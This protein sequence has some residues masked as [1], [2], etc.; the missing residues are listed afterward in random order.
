[1]ST[2]LNSITIIGLYGVRDYKIIFSDNRMI[3]VGE[4][5]SGK[6]TVL[7]IIYYTLSANWDSLFEFKF[8]EIQI[9][10]MK[11]GKKHKTVINY[12][13][14]TK[15]FAVQGIERLNYY[16]DMQLHTVSHGSRRP[17]NLSFNDIVSL[18]VEFRSSKS[19]SLNARRGLPPD[20]YKPLMESEDVKSFLKIDNQIRD[21]IDFQILYL[22]TYR[23]IEEQLKTIFPF[24]DSSEWEKKRIKIQ[25]DR[26]FEI[27]EFGMGDV[28]AAVEKKQTELQRLS[29]EQQNKLTLGYLGEIVTNKYDKVDIAKI[30]ALSDE[31]IS[32][33]LNRIEESILSSSNKHLVMET[34]SRVKKINLSE[35]PQ[36]KDKIICHYFLHLLDFHKEM[37]DKE[38]CMLKFCEKCNKYL[39]SNMIEYIR[40][41]FSCR[42]LNKVSGDFS[43]NDIKF[44]NLSSGE[45]QIVSLFSH[46]NLSQKENVFVFIDEPELSLS[47][48]WQKSFL[49]DIIDSVNCVGLV[50]STHSPFIFENNLETYVHGIN[51]FCSRG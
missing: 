48:E 6:T 23:R 42:I 17:L 16:S 28:D 46:L 24:T 32:L 40:S 20:F 41:S 8:D 27:V 43:D 21:L 51:E 30:K 38:A 13:I 22:P 2:I 15:V 49:L 1:V 7:K 37:E 45:K 26:A 12:E 33:V 36:A 35:I 9:E 31:D 11:N 34:L 14:F 29:Q 10:I 39:V 3:F 25:N 5:G 44:Q 50:A 4:N 19:N 18:T 47:V